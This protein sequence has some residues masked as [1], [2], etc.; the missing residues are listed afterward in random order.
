MT[1]SC[2]ITRAATNQTHWRRS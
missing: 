2:D 1:K